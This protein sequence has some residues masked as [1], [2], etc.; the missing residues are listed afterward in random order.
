MSD[1]STRRSARRPAGSLNSLTNRFAQW[2]TV[3]D[4]SAVLKDRQDLL[5]DEIMV[6]INTIGELD[7]KGNTWVDIDPLPFQD[8]SGKVFKY[9][10]LKA[11]KHVTPA[12][13]TPDPD[14]A[15]ALLK[16]KKLWLTKEQQ[17]AIQ[18][19]QIACPFV[20]ITVDVDTNA[21]AR[22]LFTEKI[23]DAEYESTLIEQ[24][25]SYQFRPSE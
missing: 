19:L 21:F 7:E 5:R 16:K 13:P 22:L 9:L 8:H 4:E 18:D 1:T 6:S 23:S 3:K 14:K 11:E 15:Q 20:S 24:K 17:K 10:H 2:L 25:V 12:V